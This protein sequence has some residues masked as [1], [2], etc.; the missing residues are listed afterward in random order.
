MRFL[1]AFFT[2][3]ARRPQR[4]ALPRSVRR[5]LAQSCADLTQEENALAER[6]GLPM[7]PRLLI[8]DEE[9]AVIITY[10]NRPLPEQSNR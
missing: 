3:S 7:P 4:S 9:E 2:R 5:R 6:F 1:D 10:A 8:V